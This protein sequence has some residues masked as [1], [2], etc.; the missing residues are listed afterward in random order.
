MPAMK[1]MT[2]YSDYRSIIQ[3]YCQEHHCSFRELALNTQI[4]PS[5]FSRVMVQKAN[6]SQEQLYLLAESLGLIDWELELFLLLG[7]LEN[8]GQRSHRDYIQKNILHLKEEHNQL[9][10]R[11]KTVKNQNDLSTENRKIYYE[12]SMTAVVHMFLTIKR[13]QENP[14][15]ILKNI[16]MTEFQLE[17]ELTKLEKLHIIER[18]GR[19]GKKIVLLQY[20]V[21]LAEHDPLSKNN[22]IN[23]RLEA[24]EHLRKEIPRQSDYHLSA[25]FST[26]E[27]SKIRIKNLFKQFILEAQKEAQQ[28][29]N[30]ESVYRIVFDLF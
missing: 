21:H 15:L 3:D 11:L 14:H 10:T 9:V 12:H 6:F 23:W 26:D 29:K 30:N 28:I 5:Y 20:S 24:I 13:Y 7:L 18:T 1:H 27:D 8:S 17:Q 25:V 4:H 16:P 22:H 19:E 2:E